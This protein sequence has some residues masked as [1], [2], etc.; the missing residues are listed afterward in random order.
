MT[1]GATEDAALAGRAAG[2]I[3]EELRALGVNLDFAPDADV[4]VNPANPVIGVRSFGAD[5]ARVAAMTR[6][7]VIGFQSAGVAAVAKHFPG[8]GDTD[9]DSHSGLP[10]GADL[11][12]M[13]PDLGLASMPCDR[14]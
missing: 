9:L 6:S 3:G 5:P 1:L 2:V 8:H 12:L 4:N 14:P 7:S 10:P 13:P 11:L